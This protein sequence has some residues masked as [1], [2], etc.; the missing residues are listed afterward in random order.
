MKNARILKIY[1]L[2][3]EVK[4]TDELLSIHRDLS[5]DDFMVEQYVARKDKLFAKLITEL[6]NPSLASAVSFHLVQQ[7]VEKFYTAADSAVTLKTIPDL[8]ELKQLALAA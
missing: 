8:E 3:Q 7:L 6:A 2:I 4:K 1:D 5:D